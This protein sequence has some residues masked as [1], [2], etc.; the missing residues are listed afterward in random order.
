MRSARGAGQWDR[1]QR[2]KKLMPYLIYELGPSSDH[3]PEHEAW[4]GTCLP[5]EPSLLADRHAAQ[6][7]G[8]Q[9]PGAPGH[10]S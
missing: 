4:A 6:R 1:I 9:V 10:A 8:L 7:L 2:T 5:V 3:R